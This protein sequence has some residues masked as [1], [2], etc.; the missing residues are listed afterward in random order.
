MKGERLQCFS[1][2]FNYIVK[3]KYLAK[4]TTIHRGIGRTFRQGE[5]Y[6]TKDVKNIESD[7]LDNN[8]EPVKKS[9]NGTKESS[10]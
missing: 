2:F 1:P 6:D 9:D 8:F 5:I 4:V 10:K 7:I 3:M